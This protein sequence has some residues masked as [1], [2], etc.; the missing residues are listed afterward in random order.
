MWQ[1]PRLQ[2]YDFDGGEGEGKNKNKISTKREI[3]V[4]KETNKYSCHY[5][6]K[7]DKIGR[8]FRLN[9]CTCPL[10]T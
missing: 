2:E 9:N 7:H 6:H 5:A 10:K 3:A 1:F 8:S 4:I